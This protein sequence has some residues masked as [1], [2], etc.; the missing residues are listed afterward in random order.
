[1]RTGAQLRLLRLRAWRTLLRRGFAFR[2]Q[3]T[4]THDPTNTF[5]FKDG[6]NEHLAKIGRIDGLTR[7]ILG[8]GKVNLRPENFRFGLSVRVG[9]VKGLIEK[10]AKAKTVRSQLLHPVRLNP[11]KDSI[12]MIL[13]DEIYCMNTL[14]LS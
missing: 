14:L 11:G 4:S 2:V 12:Q 1:M 6:N 5:I 7:G 8:S 13:G 9:G 3:A 10:L